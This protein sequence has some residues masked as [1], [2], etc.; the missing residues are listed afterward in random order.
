MQYQLTQLQAEQRRDSAVVQRAAA[1]AQGAA[2]APPGYGIDFL[3][4]RNHTGLPDSLK[5][6]VESLSGLAMDDV[7]VHYASPKPAQLGALAYTQGSEIHLAPG[8]ERHLPHEA[9]HVVQQKQGRVPPTLQMKGAA[10]NS[11]SHLEQEADRMGQRLQSFPLEK[12]GS[13]GGR[14]GPFALGVSA[15]SAPIQ[16][17]WSKEECNKILKKDQIGLDSVKALN[18]QGYTVLKFDNYEYERQFYL[19]EAKTQK[20][21][22]PKKMQRNGWHIRTKREI[23]ISD[24]RNDEQAA[25]TLVH[26]VTHANQY[27]DKSKPKPGYE[28]T[29]KKEYGAHIQQEKFNLK[30]GIAPKHPSFRKGDQIDET[31]IREFVDET[32]AVGG[33]QRPYTDTEPKY[34]ILETIKPWPNP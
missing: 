17:K 32:Y 8:Q 20:D 12:A 10:L 27:D 3:D 34:N 31:K 24:V 7:R 15:L 18:A 4:R 6:G 16:C 23:A 30:V 9:W 19:D 28:T 13:I 25:S 33:K 22:A 26:E 1:G 29:A 2:A 14:Q 11:D 5:A 21:G